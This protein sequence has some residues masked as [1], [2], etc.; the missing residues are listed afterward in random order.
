MNEAIIYARFS[1]ADQVKGHSIERQLDNAREVCATRNLITSPRLTFIEK[2]KSA[3]TGA[4]RSKGSLLANLEL[5]I[6][7]GAHHG[8]TLVVEHL[9]R[10]S[11]QGHDEVRDFLRACSDNGVSVAT[12]DGGRLYPAGERVQMIEVIEIILKAE[13]ARE[14]SEKKSFRIRKSF[15]AKR[16]EAAAGEGKRIASRPPSWIKRVPGGYE[17]IEEHAEIVREAHRLCQLGYGTAQIARIFNDRNYRTWRAD[18]NGWH[19]SYVGRML[20]MRTAIGEYVS[21]NHGTRILDY[22]PPVITVDC[23]NRTQAA[24]AKRAIPAARGRRGT[25]QTNLFQTIAK[26]AHCGG[27]MQMKPS[28]YVG[29]TEGRKYPSGNTGRTAIKSPASYLRCVNSLRRV[30]DHAG[31]RICTNGKLVRY[32]RLEPAVL[33]K[34]MTV[35]LDND[36]YNVSEISQ[37]RIALA[38]AERQLGHHREALENIKANLKLKVSSTLMDMLI[39]IEEKIEATQA[40][41]DGLLASLNREGG[42]KPSTE[43]LARIAQTRAAMSDPDHDTRRDARTMVHDSLCAV[44][45]DMRCDKDANTMVIVANGLAAFR[46]NNA[47]A[48][49]W[50]YDA[51]G[52]PKALV[53]LTTE[54]FAAN[55][56]L[57]EGV[58]TRAKRAA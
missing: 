46:V 54:A 37:T 4:N 49:D 47:G 48:V 3:F 55:K 39:E 9:D 38:E 26:C 21:T 23:Y 32:E 33:D 43:F 58:I 40:D 12:Y 7:A 22:Y 29:R 18:S 11:R 51:S 28:R 34:I 14:E 56:D 16:D 8:R 35:A 27:A 13:L 57:V 2:G 52:D 20:T 44:V 17:L 10:I 53:A 31:N 30:T 42:A 15:A 24:R 36:R 41:R 50:Q 19:E 5:E 6:E 1:K 25:A 45:T